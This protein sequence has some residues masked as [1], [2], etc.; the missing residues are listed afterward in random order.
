VAVSGDLLETVELTAL[1]SGATVAVEPAELFS[2]DTLTKDIWV[3]LAGSEPLAGL[4]EFGTDDGLTLVH[5]PL[6]ESGSTDQVFSYVIADDFWFTGLTLVN[7]SSGEAAVRLEAFNEDG[8]SLAT[9]Y[10][11][12]PGFGKYVRLVADIFPA[13]P[14]STI[15]QV[16]VNSTQPVLGFEIFGSYT[17]S[18][19][20]GLPGMP[21]SLEP[22]KDD[23]HRLIYPVVHSND[24]PYTGVTVSNQ[25]LTEVPFH[26]RLYTVSGAQVAETSWSLGPYVQ[27]T[28]TIQDLFPDQ[29]F[30]NQAA[31]LEIESDVASAGFEVLMTPEPMVSSL[32][33]FGECAATAPVSTEL[34]FP[35]VWS[36]SEGTTQLVLINPNLEVAPARIIGFD[37]GGEWLDT[38]EVLV[39][40]KGQYLRGLG[41]LF[42]GLDVAGIRVESDRPLRG[43]ALFVN[44]GYT[45]MGGYAGIAIK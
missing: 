28:R 44:L 5:L 36:G 31:W 41:T 37:A 14:G 39:A 9:V 8:H 6:A 1:A 40:G 26:F 33:R 4:V 10:E 34:V 3:T 20:A 2:P 15:R 23:E 45:A 11:S 17:L 35:R 19:M 7:T 21:L 30:S 25:S 43:Q 24:A 29:P 16:R 38:V 42:P 13:V 12:L 18:G 27:L 22:I 32:F